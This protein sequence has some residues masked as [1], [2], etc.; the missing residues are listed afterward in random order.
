MKKGFNYVWRTNPRFIL[1]SKCLYYSILGLLKIITSNTFNFSQSTKN[2]SFFIEWWKCKKSFRRW[3]IMF[4]FRRLTAIMMIIFV[5]TI[6]ISHQNVADV[7]KS[8]EGGLGCNM[9]LYTY[10]IT[11]SDSNGIGNKRVWQITE[12]ER[13]FPSR[14]TMLGSCFGLVMLRTMRFKWNFWLEVSI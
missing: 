1:I 11:Q 12:F 13:H 14:T 9:R 4:F 2:K 10:R 8:G 5:S 3:N 6:N 7:Q